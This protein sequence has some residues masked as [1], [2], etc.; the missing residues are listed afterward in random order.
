MFKVNIVGLIVLCTFAAACSDQ[1]DVSGEKAAMQT[2]FRGPGLHE[3]NTI[4]GSYD[5]NLF[6]ERTAIEAV[7]GS[8]LQ[9][10][11]NGGDVGLKLQKLGTREDF[12][13]KE[14]LKIGWTKFKI[15]CTS[16]GVRR[17]NPFS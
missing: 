5:P 1:G 14:S 3:G 15:V 16:T 4:I 7:A 2:N 9:M 13:I 8:C 10:N 12:F 17:P 6:T 11:G